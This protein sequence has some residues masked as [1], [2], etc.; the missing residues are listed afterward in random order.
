[1]NPN[2]DLIGR[3]GFTGEV[4]EAFAN[5]GALN[6]Y[7]MK[8]YWDYD[9][10]SKK[11]SP[12]ISIYKGG[13][14]TKIEN[15]T[16]L[17]VNAATL[18][19]DEWKLLDEAVMQVAR[20]R[21]VG[22]EDLRSHGLTY[23][24]GN[25][26]GTTILE[27][28]DV[29]ESMEATMSMDAVTRGRGDRPTFQYNYIPIPIIHVDYE[30]NARALAASR[31]LGNPLDTIA[32]EHAARR[33]AEFQEDMLFTDTTY[34]YGETD[35]RSRNSI[36]SY[37]N[38]PD[39]NEETLPLAWDNANKTGALIITDVVNMKKSSISKNHHGPWILYIPTD[40]ETVLD[41]DYDATTPGTTIRERI[42]KISGIEAI[43]VVDRLPDD[44]I[45]LVEMK[46]DTVRLIDGLPMQ[47]VQWGTEGNFVTKYKVLTIQV[48]QIR[49]DRD[50][51]CGIVHMSA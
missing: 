42:M 13:D 20:E 10:Q 44:N 32:A 50:G 16:R 14:K 28:H 47:N 49:S 7:A 29:G 26:M 6:V 23:K 18:R 36:Y 19:R 25:P 40:Y 43:K 1:M 27:W 41:K 48:P 37:L 24:L 15:Y 31:N 5:S 4:A 11:W 22:V 34:S 3:G 33:V 38:F 9:K 45:L 39:R 46:S 17:Q 51:Q 2:I 12:Y 30:I 35:S 8:P 21:L